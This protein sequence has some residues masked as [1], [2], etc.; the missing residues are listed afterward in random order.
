MSWK[1]DS[2]VT[3]RARASVNVKAQSGAVLFVFMALVFVV[4]TS[5]LVAKYSIRTLRLERLND[6]LQAMQ[7][8]KELLVGYSL[9]QARLG[10]LPCPATTPAGIENV[11]ANGCAQKL[12][13][14]PFRTLE[15]EPL[16]DG[17]GALLLYAVDESFTS[18][19]PAQ[20]N[21]SLVSPLTV[22]GGNGIFA[23]I[24]PGAPLNSLARNNL[25]YAAFL[26]GINNDGDFNTYAQ[27][28]TA[29]E[30]DVVLAL[31]PIDYWALV[32]KR[33]LIR[34]GE[35]LSAYNSA[36]GQLPWAGNFADSNS[37]SVNNSQQGG[38]PFDSASPFDWN[39]VGACSQA[40][41]IPSAL[42][43]HWEG[44]V[45]YEFCLAAEGACLSLTGDSVKNVSVV[46]MAPGSILATQNRANTALSDFFEGNNAIVDR[47]F[48]A[49]LL[50]N[51][52]NQLNDTL[53]VIF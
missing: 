50:P 14:L 53:H 16:V 41:G 23:V 21:P 3:S 12:G 13:F 2:G 28:S 33:L 30:N 22:D 9:R 29:D 36:C 39:Q 32:E 5:V 24:A 19:S 4:L 31:G 45:Y 27:G 26:E 6:S 48:Q 42:S 10:S 8:A 7:Q 25:N 15:R 20:L 38:F 37:A 43:L 46:L 35:Y 44:Q 11:T 51:L 17:Y 47:Q 18:N 49:F 52:N 34:L 1:S 40:L